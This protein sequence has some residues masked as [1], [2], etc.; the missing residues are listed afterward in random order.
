MNF[1][2]RLR[3]YCISFLFMIIAA[4]PAPAASQGAG[5]VLFQ[6]NFDPPA[7]EWSANSN[8]MLSAKEGIAGSGCLKVVISPGNTKSKDCLVS[9]PLDLNK[10]KGR[11]LLLEGMMKAQDVTRPS[12]YYLGPKLMF[13][14][15]TPSGEVWR[16]Q[17]KEEPEKKLG[18]YDWQKFSV[19]LRIPDNAEK[20]TLNLGMQDSCGT[21][22]IDD[23]KITATPDMADSKLDPGLNRAPLQKVPKFRGVMS[24]NFIK[25]AD[26]RELGQDWHANLIRFQ[27]SNPN[28]LDLSTPESFNA[29]LSGELVRLDKTLPLCHK[30]G[31]RVLIDL[32]AGPGTEQTTLL[33]NRLSCNFKNQDTLVSAWEMM[34]RKYKDNP[35]VWGY[36]I[37]NEPD[38]SYYVYT[39]GGPP[40]WNH[41]AERVAR[42]IRTIDPAKPIIIEPAIWA[43]PAGFSVF[44]PV[45]VSN[46]VY[47]VHFYAPHDFTHQGVLGR[48]AGITYPGIIAGVKWDKEQMRKQFAPVIEFQKKYNVP[49]YVGEFSVARWAPGAEQWLKDAIDIFEENGWDWTYHAFR[50][51]YGWS[52]EHGTDPSDNSMKKTTPRKEL[53]L[54]YFSRN[55]PVTQKTGTDP[56]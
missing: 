51:Y 36:D 18:T 33:S 50:E 43:Q 13:Y 7:K 41:L 21:I 37:L 32:H 19:F 5:E 29:W 38:E 4:I 39:P 10:M 24:G 6:E 22:W 23:I 49:V 47:S 9:I 52:V 27:L 53:L 17:Q 8:V 34:A 48:P 28:K 2:K 31:I 35:D 45:N 46:V 14:L 30:Y 12:K 3:L 11:G 25:D 42:A 26:M 40:D 20:L 54:K 56:L 44:K 16:D 1:K 15:K 55:I